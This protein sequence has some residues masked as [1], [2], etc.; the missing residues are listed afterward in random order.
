MEVEMGKEKLQ[1]TLL[2]SLFKIITRKDVLH[3]EV[4]NINE[5]AK[6]K[7]PTLKK[8]KKCHVG[9]PNFFVATL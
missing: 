7:V 6:Q 1:Q 9:Q 3:K 2:T 8:V 5:S 4:E